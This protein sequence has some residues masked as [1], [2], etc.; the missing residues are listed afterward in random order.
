[1]GGGGRR[2]TRMKHRPGNRRAGSVQLLTLRSYRGRRRPDAMIPVPAVAARN[3]RTAAEGAEA[4][5]MVCVLLG[6]LGVRADLR[7]AQNAVGQPQS[8]RERTIP[9]VREVWVATVQPSPDHVQ[10]PGF[11]RI[12][13]LNASGSVSTRNADTPS[14]ARASSWPKSPSTSLTLERISSGIMDRPR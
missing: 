14:Y 2:S 11:S 3:T 6:V 9:E 1:M 12:Q 7:H 4:R 8:P 10:L 13:K 5:W